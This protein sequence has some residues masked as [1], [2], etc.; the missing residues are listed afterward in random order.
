VGNRR[1]GNHTKTYLNEFFNG[2]TPVKILT[3]ALAA[4]KPSQRK[5]LRLRQ[6]AGLIILTEFMC[7]VQNV[8]PLS[9]N[10]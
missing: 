2:D 1:W 6:V 7:I 8:E 4:D 3:G 10:T 9:T 5:M